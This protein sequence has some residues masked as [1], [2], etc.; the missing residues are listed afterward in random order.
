MLRGADK[1]HLEAEA[2]K[3]ELNARNRKQKPGSKGEEDTQSR[4]GAQN[5]QQRRT[6]AW[7]PVLTRH[8]ERGV[9]CPVPTV[10]ISPRGALNEKA[11]TLTYFKCL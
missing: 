1:Q 5:T 4:G 3:P 8:T 7:N 10:R 11:Y 6:K 2:Y 9:L